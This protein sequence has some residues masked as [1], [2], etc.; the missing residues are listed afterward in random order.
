MLRLFNILT[1]LCLSMYSSGQGCT[2]DCQSNF[3]RGEV[4]QYELVYHWGFIKARAGQVTFTV[5][6][7][8]VDGQAY[9]CFK[10]H[11]SSM[12]NWDW[13]Y[14]VNSSYLSFTDQD[15]YPIF[16]SRKG[17]EGPETYDRE[18]RVIGNQ[19][20]LS[21]VDEDGNRTEQLL[22]LEACSF[23]VISAIYYC[24]SIDF[25]KLEINTMLPLN[26]FLDGETHESY[27]RFVGFADWQDPRTEEVHKCIVFKP[28]LIDGTVFSAGENMTVYVSDT[29]EKTPLYIET[30]LV[31]GKA[32]V[33]LIK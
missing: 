32:E 3:S 23:D 25:S 20:F 31:V 22:L 14:H 28:W 30:D 1:L 4:L 12:P 10:G 8:L 17:K 5:G 29:P 9:T 6:D 11:G 24:R 19:A 16:F 27:V 33:Y 21:Q 18:Y 2:D 26:L 13:F 15:L 7:T